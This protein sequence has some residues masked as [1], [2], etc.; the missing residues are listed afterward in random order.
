M[1]TRLTIL[2]VSFIF[3]FC[4]MSCTNTKKND[5]IILKEKIIIND[6]L[7][8]NDSTI[9]P[10]NNKLCDV[11]WE[12]I[13]V[14][15]ENVNNYIYTNIPY[16]IFSNDSSYILI[17][18][19]CNTYIGECKIKQ[20]NRIKFDNIII[21]E[22]KYPIDALER[23]IIYCLASSNNYLLNNNNLTLLH[24]DKPIGFLVTNSEN[25]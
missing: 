7:I 8:S 24:N 12:F 4:I 3:A 2:L 11:T 5:N 17:N 16:V 22:E 23:E 1:K 21:K 6:T 25:Q 10:A 15:G 14:N 20:D 18:G 13:F 9:P 19:G